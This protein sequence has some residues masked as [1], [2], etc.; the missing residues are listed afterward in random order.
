MT[1]SLSFLFALGMVYLFALFLI[2]YCADH[3]YIPNKVVRHPATFVLSLGVVVTSGAYYGMIPLAHGTG[4]LYLEYYVG[5]ALC[6]LLARHLIIPLYRVCKSNQLSSLADLMAF[7]YR[8]QSVGSVITVLMLLAVL[9]LIAMQIKMVAD[10]TFLLSQTGLLDDNH[11]GQHVGL[12]L[13]FCVFISLFTLLFGTRRQRHNGLVTAIAAD[14]LF[15]CLMFIA[16]G[17]IATTEVFGGV[18]NMQGWL[19]DNPA[20]LA[21]LTES[22]HSGST[23]TLLMVSFAAALGMPHLFHM[24]YAENASSEAVR[25]SSWGMPLFLLLL[26]LPVLPI[27][28]AYLA[29]GSQAPLEYAPLGIGIA[30]NSPLLTAFIYVGGLSAASGMTIVATLALAS[31]SL[32]HLVTP[33]Y[34]PGPSRD[35]YDWLQRVRR[36]LIFGLIMGGFILF[37]F[38]TNFDQIFIYGIISFA[39]ISQFFPGILAIQYFPAASRT[40][41]FAGLI[42]GLSIWLFTLILGHQGLATEILPGW[43]NIDTPNDLWILTAWT[44]LIINALIFTAGSLLFPPSTEENIAARNCA[45]NKIMMPR[46]E[47]LSFSSIPELEQQL[48]D[49][50]GTSTAKQEINRA[51]NDLKLG[52]KE[53]RIYHLRRLREQ[54]ERNLSHLLGPSVAHS[55]IESNPA[56]TS[57]MQQQGSDIRLMEVRLESYREYLTGVAVELDDLRRLHRQTLLNLPIGVCTLGPNQEILMWNTSMEKLTGIPSFQT[58]GALADALPLPW[59]ELIVDFAS[60]TEEDRHRATVTIENKPRWLSLHKTRQVPSNPNADDMVILVEDV[61]DLQ[62]LEQELMHSERLASIGRLAAG[63]AHEIGNPVTGIACLA[64]NLGYESDDPAAV[65]QSANDIITQT[66]RISS[67]V[68]T[69]VN[70]SHSGRQISSREHEAV[71]LSH[72][73]NEAIKLLSL[74][75]DAQTVSF[76]NQCDSSILIGDYQRLLQVFVNLLNNARD[77]SEEDGKIIVE[78]RQEASN[79]IVTVTDSGHGIPVDQLDRLYEPFFTTRDPGKGTGLGLALVFSIIEE[80]GASIKAT[81]PTHDNRGSRFTLSFPVARNSNKQ[82]E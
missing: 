22:T 52:N 32:N 1:F 49:S 48:V 24:L 25:T 47:A 73:V 4:Y 82:S 15:K 81:S 69:L 29:T 74:D 71:D 36:G 60:T 61:T 70:F 28:W 3:K 21:A 54:L 58:S 16:I 62:L 55:I 76:L 75:R 50:L 42:S 9:P 64:Q 72:C 30:L 80:H 38:L 19:N 27:L 46:Q 39:T 79:I 63:V 10:T 14:S 57:N 40:G 13:V 56:K 6:F 31:M 59:R 33:F 53:T 45:H 20:Q 66:E 68:E 35:I 44:S 78:S 2:A 43:L 5:I 17:V 8:S 34:K 7:R 37:R 26:S 11:K 67:I 65:L 77:A 18:E 41:F 23:R 51:L 12:A